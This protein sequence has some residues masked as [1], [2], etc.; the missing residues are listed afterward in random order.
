MAGKTLKEVSVRELNKYV[1]FSQISGSFKSDEAAFSKWLK[2]A[3]KSDKLLKSTL[4]SIDDSA[5]T[6]EKRVELYK[7]L[8]V[9]ATKYGKLTD[10]NLHLIKD[11]LLP[12]E[13]KITLEKNLQKKS[14]EIMNK[15][16]KK[17]LQT[18][19]EIFKISHQMQLE[20]NVTWSNYR[21]LYN[22][23][24]ESARKAN[25]EIGQSIHNV[26]DL[27]ET[28]NKLLGAGWKDINPG[29]LTNVSASV[30]TLQK[31][32]GKLDERLITGFEQSYRLFGSQTDVFVT[33]IGNRLNAFSNT[34]G[35]KVDMLQDVV[36]GMMDSNNFIHRSNMQ[37]Q[38]Q[39][40]ENLIRAAALAGAIGLT[41]ATFVTN[42]AKTSQF[43]TMEQMAPIFQSGALLQG[44]DTSRF[45][46]QMI[47]GQYD[48]ATMQLLE[49]ISTTLNNVDD[50]YLR[51]EYMS[52]IGSAFGFSVD[53]LNR[54]ATHGGNLSAYDQNLQ[55]K[56]VDVNTSMEDELAGLRMDVVDRMENWYLNTS[57]SQGL[58]SFMQEMGLYGMY[59]LMSGVG[60]QL[61]TMIWQLHSINASINAQTAATLGGGLPA[62]GGSNAFGAFGKGGKISGE[63]ALG[64]AGLA[65]GGT[66]LS[67]W[68]Q[69]AQQNLNTDDA[70][71][72][73]GG[74]YLTT[75][76]DMATFGG[77][78][79]MAGGLTGAAIGATIGLTSGIIKSIAGA[80][81]RKAKQQELED[82][83]RA[84]R[85]AA[86]N[87]SSSGYIGQDP[88]VVA[89]KDLENAVVGT[90]NG[91]Q[92][93]NKVIDITNATYQK[94]TTINTRLKSA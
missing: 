51:A 66:L 36:A 49:S 9:N 35:V 42:L 24:Y 16:L 43:G 68:G 73:I 80:D 86:L 83:Q 87:Q 92:E 45:Q 78:G 54:I 21:R 65:F 3:N 17:S 64:G 39:A 94:T 15:L 58:G 90:L 84:A 7:S 81:E 26:K 11:K 61:F 18:N 59:D 63:Q 93:E 14:Q 52:Q 67:D 38:I 89:I 30:M 34:F 46:Q 4:K 27:V 62:G 53:E 70:T 20:S 32:L 77:I 6:E 91:I 69:N 5:V 82:Q 28:Q 25:Q 47:A 22:E 72:N 76:G 13:E 74:G 19:Q 75:L 10:K 56:L 29:V 85:K 37:A 44:F 60:K 8:L 71:A 2:L 23:A 48:T 50:H 12:L 57:F 41:S 33:Q 55:D 88:I 40:N 31:T 1:D 79:M